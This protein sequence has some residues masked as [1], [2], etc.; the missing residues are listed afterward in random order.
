MSLIFFPR[1]CT[2][3]DL[4]GIQIAKRLS[5]QINPDPNNIK[6]DDVCIYIKM[7]PIH[8]AV[9]YIDLVDNVRYVDVLKKHPEFKGIAISKTAFE[10]IKNRIKNEIVLIPHHHCNFERFRN[11]VR[12]YPT[13][14]GFCGFFKSILPYYADLKYAFDKKGFDFQLCTRYDTREQVCN[15]Y[16]TIDIQIIWRDLRGTDWGRWIIPELK[17]PLKISNA[18]S[19]GVPT[20]AYPEKNFIAEYDGAFVP[21][22]SIDELID[23]VCL[24]R[25]A[26]GF[27]RDIA[28]KARI[29]SEE[30]HIDNIIKLYL[31]LEK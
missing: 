4:R 12:R 20:V 29:K 5:A 23:R 31:T 27:C 21:A 19:F 16:K 8:G 11:P 22:Y 2:T 15:F 18:G 26:P 28:E 30:Y 9:S 3:G 1:R 6:K 13:V 14:V 10:Y 7:H 24:L 17:N 25:D